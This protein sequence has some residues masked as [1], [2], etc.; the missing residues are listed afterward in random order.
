MQLL[1]VKDLAKVL[2]TSVRQIWR[3]R[4]AGQLPPHIKIGGS[5]RWDERDLAAWIERQ[6]QATKKNL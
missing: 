5:V 1:T 2:K 4:A 3:L 6:K